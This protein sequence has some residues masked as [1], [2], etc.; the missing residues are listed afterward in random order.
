M[1]PFA[2]DVPTNDVP[3]DVWGYVIAAYVVTWVAW[4]LYALLLFAL[5]AIQK[6]GTP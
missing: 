1:I 3:T 6:R 5:R 4:G 2:A